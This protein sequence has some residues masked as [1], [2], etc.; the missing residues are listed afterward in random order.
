MLL[1][2]KNNDIG[3]RIGFININHIYP[4]LDQLRV[5]LSDQKEDVKILGI[6]ESFLN[7]S[8]SD[9]EISIS[10]V[11]TLRRDR[12]SKSGGGLVVY[13]D[14]TTPFVRKNEFEINDI[15]CIWIEVKL[16]FSKGVYVCLVYRPPDSKAEWV[17]SFHNMLNVPYSNR[18]DIIIMGD[19]NFDLLSN[20]GCNSW[21]EVIC[22]FN[23]RQL[24]KQRTRVTANSAT[25]IDHVYCTNENL[26][27]NV[28]VP[29]IRISDHYPVYFTMKC[30]KYKVRKANH[31]SVMYRDI[32][33]IDKDLFLL[34]LSNCNWQEIYSQNDPNSALTLWQTMLV[35][36]IN[37]HA[38][39]KHKR[40]KR[41][42]QPEWF[43]DEIK[44][45]IRR[46]DNANAKDPVAYKFWRNKV[47]KLIKQGKRNYFQ[48]AISSKSGDTKAIWKILRNVQSNNATLQDNGVSLLNVN[49]E[50]VTDE[51]CI[52]NAFNSFFTSIQDYYEAKNQYQ[53]NRSLKKLQ[54]YISSILPRDVTFSIPYITEEYVLKYLSSMDTSKATGTDEIS[55]Y[56]IKLSA[57]YIA[58]GLTYIIN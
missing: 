51:K 36:T 37:K 11:K 56:V 18:Q 1:Q 30:N 5:F 47:T 52:A 10:G 13:I 26:V 38:K 50:E 14:N 42:R 34:D 22:H 27:S 25:L 46:R 20:T 32:T 4:K 53:E 48:S 31:I 28:S 7:D 12:I 19:F 9:S 39:P 29:Y 41:R 24:V 45:A 6:T 58:P 8:F 23:L 16:P 44:Q 3:L 21:N 2:P 49:D 43:N 17:T 35:D 54:L 40:V 55:A 15:E 57:K 33:K